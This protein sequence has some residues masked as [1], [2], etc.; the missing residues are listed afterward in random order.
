MQKKLTKLLLS[1][2]I[3][4]NSLQGMK[5]SRA[6]RCASY[7]G[8]IAVARLA[9]VAPER[10]IAYAFLAVAYLAPNPE[11]DMFSALSQTKAAF[12]YELFGYQVFF[13]S[14][15]AADILNKTVR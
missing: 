6:E 7:R 5:R 10:I 15:E 11:F 14:D 3:G 12:G 1:D 8:C 2:T 9:S 4:R 13:A